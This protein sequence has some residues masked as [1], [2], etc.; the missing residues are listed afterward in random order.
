MRMGLLHDVDGVP[1]D[2]RLFPGNQNDMSTMLPMT[3]KA[4]PKDAP[5]SEGERVVVITD[6]GLNIVANIA[7]CALDGNRFAF[8]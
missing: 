5:K 7:A 4:G 1:L 3:K 6:K 8:S 2:F